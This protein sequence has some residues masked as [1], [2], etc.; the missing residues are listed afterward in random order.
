MERWGRHAGAVCLLESV[1]ISSTWNCFSLLASISVSLQ[2]ESPFG[3]THLPNAGK[4]LKLRTCW[5]RFP[6]ETVY[7][8]RESYAKSPTSHLLRTNK[9]NCCFLFK[10]QDINQSFFTPIVCEVQILD[11]LLLSAQCLIHFLIFALFYYTQNSTI[12]PKIVYPP[13]SVNW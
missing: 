11:S 8:V 5:S 12:S 6:K 10:N 9:Y 4:T 3:C 1:F 7:I 13:I 2:A